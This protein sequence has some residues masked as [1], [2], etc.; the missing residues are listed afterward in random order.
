[1]AAPVLDDRLER[2]AELAIHVGA[3]VQSGQTV[4]V[5]AMIDHAPLAR[6]LARA[7]YAAGAKYVD[8]RYTD[9]HV[10]R[11]MIELGPDD[12]LEHTPGWLK[13]RMRAAG[14]NALVGTT[15]DPEP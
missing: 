14:G 10:R 9:Q 15:G 2:Y 7:A 13:T 5:N 3:N 4:L 8:V 12:A 6:A 11:A 1:M